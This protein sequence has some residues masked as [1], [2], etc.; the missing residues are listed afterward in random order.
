MASPEYCNAHKQRLR[1]VRD[2]SCV[3]SRGSEFRSQHP[4]RT[5]H[6]TA[7]CS[8]TTLKFLKIV[9]RISILL[10]VGMHA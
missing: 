9:L 6:K 10:Y 7:Y 8:K 1:G 5:A 3:S 4:H 2:G